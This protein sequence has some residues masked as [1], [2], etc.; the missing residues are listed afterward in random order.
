MPTQSGARARLAA[1]REQ[2]PNADQLKADAATEHDELPPETWDV[3]S[4]CWPGGWKTIPGITDDHYVVSCE[5]G[6]FERP[7]LAEDDEDA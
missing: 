7:A 5:H 1:A 4:T 2:V 3:C 6:H